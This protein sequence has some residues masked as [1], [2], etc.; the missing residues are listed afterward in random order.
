[1]KKSTFSRLISYV[2]KYKGYMFASL[3]FA[4]ISNILIAI[5]AVNSGKVY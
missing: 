4:L 1:M 5:Y 3:I 2:S